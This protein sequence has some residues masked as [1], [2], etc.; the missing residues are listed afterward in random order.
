MLSPQQL[1]HRLY[2]YDSI[3]GKDGRS[4][5]EGVFKVL[6][7]KFK[8]KQKNGVVLSDLKVTDVIDSV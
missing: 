6:A 8:K 7:N 5:M 4:A 3:L 1:V 2:P